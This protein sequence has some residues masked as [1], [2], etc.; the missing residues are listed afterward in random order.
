MSSE[1]NKEKENNLI[2]WLIEIENKLYS[3]LCIMYVRLVNKKNNKAGTK[4]WKCEGK[5]LGRRARNSLL[6]KWHFIQH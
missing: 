6:R 4:S 3:M 1:Q 5:H 2:F